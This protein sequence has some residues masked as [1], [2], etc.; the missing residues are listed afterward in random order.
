[1]GKVGMR[2]GGGGWDEVG[3]GK[4]GQGGM[5]YRWGWRSVLMLIISVYRLI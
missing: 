1:M 5:G 4:W 2:W 3:W